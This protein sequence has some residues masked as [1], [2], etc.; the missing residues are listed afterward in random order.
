M[1]TIRRVGPPIIWVLVVWTV[2]GCTRSEPTAQT[3]E[4]GSAH[5][6]AGDKQRHDT[7]VAASVPQD[8]GTDVGVATS[9]TTTCHA[10][11][12]MPF[13]LPALTGGLQAVKALLEA[14]T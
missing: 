3:I 8:A 13:A 5:R 7:S 2:I 10:E 6:A 12:S 11:A 9:D 4:T 14:G 1:P